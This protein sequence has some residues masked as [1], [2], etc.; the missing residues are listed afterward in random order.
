MHDTHILTDVGCRNEWENGRKVG[1]AM[2]IT[3]NYYR[4]L[5]LCCVDEISLWVDDEKI[6][7]KMLYVQHKGREYAYEEILADDFQTDF[8][9]NFGEYLRVVVRKEGGVEQGVHKVKLRLGT[10]RSYTPTMVS[11]CEKML[12]FA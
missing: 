2:N 1:Y 4:G 12:I 11:T 6:D 3:I 10:R 5:P 7:P 8:Y 9:W